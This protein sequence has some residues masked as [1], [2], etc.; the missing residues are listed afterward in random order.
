MI[1]KL[2]VLLIAVALLS[3]C[4]LEI[5]GCSE[6]KKIQIPIGPIE[7]PKMRKPPKLAPVEPKSLPG[8]VDDGTFSNLPEK[9]A[10]YRLGPG[11]KIKIRVEEAP[12]LEEEL[13]VSVDGTILPKM[14]N[15]I[16]VLDNSIAEIEAD[17]KKRYGKL[18][19]EP[20]VS[21]WLKEGRQLY[22]FVAG[23]LP[24]S[25]R[26]TMT[27][28]PSLL[29]VLTLA[30]WTEDSPVRSVTVV[31]IDKTESET[32]SK[33]KSV[34]LDNLIGGRSLKN[35]VIIKPQDLII[36]AKDFPIT[37]TGAV[38][39]PGKYNLDGA[40]Q[41]SIAWVIA[42]AQGIKGDAA[43]NAVRVI[44]KN[45]IERLIDLN[46][47]LFGDANEKIDFIS[48]GETLYIPTSKKIKIYVLGMVNQ[49]GQF[50]VAEGT[51]VS[52]A[53]A[54]ADFERFGAVLDSATLI[55]G[56]FK[57][58]QES[59]TFNL[60]AVL[61]GKIEQNYRMLDGSVLFI[62]ESTTSDVLDFLN[63]LLAPLA[64]TLN[65]ATGVERLSDSGDEDK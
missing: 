37:V 42:K 4:A 10:E 12:N 2:P 7:P 17:L 27:G 1:R 21:V 3:L 13:I 54:L 41:R 28:Q 56:Y 18:I 57:G 46:P 25:G 34:N 16:K 45:G 14:L 20:N 35:N 9:D 24:R 6:P 43:L 55:T 53:I 5:C 64:G 31:R 19:R 49:P 15:P 60:E 51:T 62:P 29:E 38:N 58:Q 33:F 32:K 65:V 36:A 59:V 26:L 61:E 22:V 50:V 47:I 11:D 40:T 39:K 63:R 44:G 48:P 23:S 30:G 8:E 52:Q